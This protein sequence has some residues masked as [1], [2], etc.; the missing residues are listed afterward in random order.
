[1]KYFFVLTSSD[2]TLISSCSLDV[3]LAQTPYSRLTGQRKKAKITKKPEK[4]SSKRQ[5]KKNMSFF[6]KTVKSRQYNLK[7]ITL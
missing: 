3:A 5:C 2:E 7:D 4:I 6:K 1:M